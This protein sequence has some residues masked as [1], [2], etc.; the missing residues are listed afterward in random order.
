MRGVHTSGAIGVALWVAA[1]GPAPGYWEDK[2]DPYASM[3]SPLFQGQSIRGRWVGEGRQS[4]G[5]R[6]QMELDIANT[7]EGPCAIVH[8][9]DLDCM[10]YWTCDGGSEASRI[11]ATEHIT[12]GAG[13]CADNIPVDAGFSSDGE[14]LV[15]EARAGEI[16]A[17]A[18]LDRARSE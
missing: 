10:G 7:D 8:Y 17:G 4:D 15:F 13:R 18:R 12:H 14:Q 16:V 9:P 11:R 5:P 6:W 2:T 1:C 3:K